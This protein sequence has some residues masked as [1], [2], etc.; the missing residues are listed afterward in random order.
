M[1]AKHQA[2]ELHCPIPTPLLPQVVDHLKK[3]YGKQAARVLNVVL[4]SKGGVSGGT[5]ARWAGSWRSW[6]SADGGAGSAMHCFCPLSQFYTALNKSPQLPCS[7]SGMN[8]FAEMKARPE[9]RGE[10]PTAPTCCPSMSACLRGISAV[11]PPAPAAAL[12]H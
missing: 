1:H 10:P 6:R 9:L 2:L 4:G 3:R 8:A 11:W 12:N 7:R 5:I